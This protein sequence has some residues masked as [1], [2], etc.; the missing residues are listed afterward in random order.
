VI[1][2][3]VISF[4]VAVGAGI[5]LTEQIANPGKVKPV[6]SILCGISLPFLIIAVIALVSLLKQQS[7]Q[8]MLRVY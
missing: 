2:T 8:N 7:G 4:F 6:R 5:L 3:V 1:I